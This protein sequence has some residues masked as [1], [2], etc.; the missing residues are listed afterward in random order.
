MFPGGHDLQ[1]TDVF[2]V[3]VTEEG[4]LFIGFKG[5]DQKYFKLEECNF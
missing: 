2:P 4:R 5:L 3:K 1:S